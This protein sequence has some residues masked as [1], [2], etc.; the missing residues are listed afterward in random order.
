M[1]EHVPD[2][3]AKFYAATQVMDD[4]RHVE[5]YA[6]LLH[7]KFELSHP[8]T[9]PLQALLNNVIEESRWDFTYL[10]MQVMIEGL[11]LAAFQ[12]I[13]DLICNLVAT[14][15]H[16]TADSFL[17]GQHAYLYRGKCTY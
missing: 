7:E 10:G 16:G 4:A 9:P 2:L 1:V 14:N 5:T 8:M 11:A 15:N 13:R 3:D 12:A 6:P 17:K